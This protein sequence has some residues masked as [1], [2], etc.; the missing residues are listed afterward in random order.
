MIFL[1]QIRSLIWGVPGPRSSSELTSSSGAQEGP[2]L[3]GCRPE[4]SP[5]SH[6]R[7]WRPGSGPA[8]AHP[9]FWALGWRLQISQVPSNGVW[10]PYR[11]QRL[12]RRAPLAGMG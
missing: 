9:P 1:A 5:E 10:E 2:S 3:A 11:V 8:E 6:G 4:G 7:G 12:G